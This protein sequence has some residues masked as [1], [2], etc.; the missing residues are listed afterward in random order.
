MDTS[1]NFFQQ[2]HP[3]SIRGRTLGP[4]NRRNNFAPKQMALSQ[5]TSVNTYSNFVHTHIQTYSKNCTPQAL[6]AFAENEV[7][8]NERRQII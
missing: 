1:H 3:K 7:E 2:K 4:F 8:E 5:K 6:R